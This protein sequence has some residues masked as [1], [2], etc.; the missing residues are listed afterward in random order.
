MSRTHVLSLLALILVPAFTAFSTSSTPIAPV[1]EENQNVVRF[2][3][4]YQQRKDGSAQS[5]VPFYLQGYGLI[6]NAEEH[7][8]A[9]AAFRLLNCRN[10]NTSWSFQLFDEV[11]LADVQKFLPKDFDKTKFTGTLTATP[12]FVK[13][14]ETSRM[15]IWFFIANEDSV[16]AFFPEAN[17]S[18]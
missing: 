11:P 6:E 7:K 1:V 3:Y 13:N 10:M 4:D 12:V 17:W 9:L 14:P 5:S 18:L 2:V 15:A 16:V 8:K